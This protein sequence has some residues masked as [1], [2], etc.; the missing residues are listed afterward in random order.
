MKIKYCSIMLSIILSTIGR[1]SAEELSTQYQ[2]TDPKTGKVV[3]R[4]YPP[5]NLQM[6]QVERRGNIVILEVLGKH[7]FSDAVNLNT[8][9]SAQIASQ[10]STAI[11][12]C[13]T[14]AR[15][16]FAWKDRE[17]V[18]IE[19]E[20]I[21][22]TSTDTGEVRQALILSVNAKNSYG[23]YGGAEYVQCILGTDHLTPIKVSKWP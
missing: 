5:A 17:S 21:K 11:N 19:G 3:T 23:A 13:L 4:D 1:A 15:E 18:R 7:K 10:P 8:P 2:W 12:N 22:T 14:A 16:K 20:P 6:R 9:Q